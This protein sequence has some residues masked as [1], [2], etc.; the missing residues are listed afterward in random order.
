M[1]MH[2]EHAAAVF[3]QYF[4]ATAALTL[5]RET[6]E[7]RMLWA[8]VE[9]DAPR[10]HT[11]F[12]EEWFAELLATHGIPTPEATRAVANAVQPRIETGGAPSGLG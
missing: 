12:D 2:P 11:P 4:L 10:M 3:A 8:A 5:G 7:A 6:V 9:Q 1:P